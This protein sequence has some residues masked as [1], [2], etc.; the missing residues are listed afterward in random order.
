MAGG[1]EHRAWGRRETG[2]VREAAQQAGA[3]YRRRPLRDAGTMDFIPLGV[4]ARPRAERGSHPATH[5]HRLATV[6]G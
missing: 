5:T 6:A 3:Q 2:V 4:S 1:A